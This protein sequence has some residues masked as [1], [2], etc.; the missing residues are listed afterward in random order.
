MV[1]EIVQRAWCDLHM[2]SDERAEMTETHAVTIDGTAYTLD[3]C[4]EHVA[5]FERFA[6]L[7]RNGSARVPRNGTTTKNGAKGGGKANADVRLDGRATAKDSDH[8]RVCIACGHVC[9]SQGGFKDHVRRVHDS[10][11]AELYGTACA[12]CGRQCESI[13]ALGVHA[14]RTHVSE[15]VYDVATLFVIASSRGD[16]HGIVAERLG[17]VAHI[18][19]AEPTTLDVVV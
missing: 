18:K 5:D 19:G 11:I 3:L 16:E 14:S 15:G 9:T 17:K 7:V 10:S 8:E 4:A 2:L 1:R 13:Q 6:E 12:L